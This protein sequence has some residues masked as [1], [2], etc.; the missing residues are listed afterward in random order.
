MNRT[1]NKQIQLSLQLENIGVPGFSLSQAHYSKTIYC[2]PSNNDVFYIFIFVYLYYLTHP[3]LHKYSPSSL[4]PT[5][6]IGMTM[7]LLPW[8]S[9][10]CHFA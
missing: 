9:S 1:G 3:L 10:V 6:V 5:G 8:G 4:V 2:H 7:C